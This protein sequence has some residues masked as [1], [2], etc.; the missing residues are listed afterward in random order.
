MEVILMSN[1]KSVK[2]QGAAIPIKT[3]NYYLQNKTTKC[4]PKKSSELTYDEKLQRDQVIANFMV[5]FSNIVMKKRKDRDLSQTE[6]AKRA[7]TTRIT[8]SQIE[9]LQI[10]PNLATV[11]SIL[12]T[13]G[14]RLVIEEKSNESFSP[15]V[16]IGNSISE[17]ELRKLMLKDSPEHIG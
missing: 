15:H 17:T 13:F 5:P 9:N 11:L 10:V 2:S 14:L 1:K 6:L 4:R 8:I 7:F 12:D 3:K 16:E